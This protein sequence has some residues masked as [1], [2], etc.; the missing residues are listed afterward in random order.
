MLLGVYHPKFLLVTTPSYTFNARFTPPDSPRSARNGYPDPTG[1]TDRIF[2]HSDHKF[3]WTKDEFETWCDETAKEWGYDV[4]RTSIGRPLE[5]DPWGR[6]EELEG[7]SSVAVFRRRGDMD[8]KRRED[9]GRARI[10]ELA[11]SRDPHEALAVHNH[12]ANPAA[13]RPKSLSEIADSVKSKMEE[14]R[15]AFIRV[16]EI[17][18]EPTIGTS[19]GGWI[20]LLVRAV[21]ESPDLNMKRDVDGVVMKQSSMWSI[22]LVGAV[23]FPANCWSD[24]ASTSVDYIPPDWTPGEG[25]LDSWDDSDA[26][27]STGIEGDVSAFTSDNDGDEESDSGT[28]T[29][30]K[31]S[32]W[33]ESLDRE[34]DERTRS[35]WGVSGGWG[36]SDMEGSWS[37]HIPSASSSTAG[38]DGDESGDTTS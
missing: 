9:Q 13:M 2:R 31:R 34:A 16:E 5:L 35:G 33:K 28:T 37:N 7:A 20:E 22:E 25:P 17:W 36:A 24:E 1:R 12:A 27:G 14:F 3:E 21:E 11:L 15:E 10:Q 38:W 23:G 4:E 32:E 29:W 19:C 18:F 26:E 8:N 30:K 6:D